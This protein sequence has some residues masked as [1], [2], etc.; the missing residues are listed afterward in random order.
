MSD[1]PAARCPPLPDAP[2]TDNKSDP[3]VFF[4]LWNRRDEYTD[5][6][7][8]AIRHGADPFAASFAFTP[9]GIRRRPTEDES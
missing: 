7:L 1:N 8:L 2:A 5:P 3:M 6:I 4:H 9:E